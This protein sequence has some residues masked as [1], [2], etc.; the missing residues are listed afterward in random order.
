M[1]RGQPV[2]IHQP[3]GAMAAALREVW[4][5]VRTHLNGAGERGEVG[6]WS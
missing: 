1:V 3:E 2:T 6:G 4:A 5:R